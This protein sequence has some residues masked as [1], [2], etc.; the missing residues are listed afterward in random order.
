VIGGKAFTEQYILTALIQERLEAA[1]CRTQLREGLGS[2]ILFEALERG[3]IDAYVDYTG[4]ILATIMH[5]GGSY[6]PAETLVDVAAYLK[7]EHG[8]VTVGPLG[9]ENSYV[10]AMRRGQAN[11]LGIRTLADLA[12]QASQLRAG[13]DSEFFARREW[14]RVQELYG[15]TFQKEVTMDAALMYGAIGQGQLD[16]IA[17]YSTDGRIDA[18]DLVILDDPRR[19]LPPYDAILLVSSRLARDP[20]ALQALRPLVNSI[21][22]EAMRGANLLVDNQ[23]QTPRQAADRLKIR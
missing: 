8:I 4:T 23:G 15:L 10:F 21:S 3:Q 18:H 5:G 11:S 2:T 9:F 22:T 19:A 6:S 7:A 1:G 17:A 16:V 20:T 14:Q 12:R 13:T